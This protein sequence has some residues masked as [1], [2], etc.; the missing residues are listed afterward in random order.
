MQ[1]AG[2]NLSVFAIFSNFMSIKQRV[3]LMKSFIE[4]QFAYC[5]LIWMF[6][7]RGVNNKINHLHECSLRIV[8]KDKNSS[9]K[10]LLKKDNSFTVHHRNVQ[11]L[12]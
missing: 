4:S 8:C 7:G 11:S 12:S 9:I 2:K 10:E 3:I 1:K 6:H 5:P